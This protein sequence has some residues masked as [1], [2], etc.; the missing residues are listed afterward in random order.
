VD[1]RDVVPFI[2]WPWLIVSVVILVRRSIDKRT[3]SIA[4]EPLPEIVPP[5]RL[6]PLADPAA[7]EG[8]PPAPPPT[9]PAW[10]TGGPPAPVIPEGASIFDPPS[11]VPPAPPRAAIADMV[12]GIQMPCDL[13]PLVGVDRPVGARESAAFVTRTHDATTVGRAMGEEL[14]RLDF[15]LTTR[16]ATEV[17]ATRGDDWLL[18][19]VHG[20]ADS[21]ERGDRPAFP[22]AGPGSVVV[23]LWTE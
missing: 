21:V 6:P 12:R 10:P 16:H 8:D 19:A 5:P 2:F 22:G 14:R 4:P 9:A 13:T 3:G 15:E 11:V 17:V 1:F 7:P 23:E 18:V 20:S